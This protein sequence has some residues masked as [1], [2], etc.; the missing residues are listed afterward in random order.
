MQTR[1]VSKRNFFTVVVTCMLLIAALASSAIRAEQTAGALCADCHEEIV[2]SY[3]KT[4]HGTTISAMPDRAHSVCESCHGAAVEHASTGDPELIFNPANTDQFQA[5]L[6]CLNC[7]SDG[8]L[9]NWEFSDH[10]GG[11]ATCSDCHTTHGGST[12]KESGEALCYSCHIEVKAATYLP[13]HHPIVEGKLECADCHGVHGEPAKLTADNTG[14]ELCLS[15]HMEQEGPFVYEHDPVNE[16]CNIC[17][18][19]HG[20]VAD[21]LLRYNEPALCLNCHA[22]HFHASV[23][24]QDGEFTPPLADDRTTMSTTDGWKKGMLTKCTQCHSQIHGSDMP[25]QAIPT[26]GNALTR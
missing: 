3:G 26:G 1:I 25:S 11:G 19:P 14:R 10:N 20:T 17:H 4:S 5:D 18:A 21:K 7:H 23:E 8:I 22:M 12:A 6:L 16:D 9:D 2:A 24:G 13:S 15:C